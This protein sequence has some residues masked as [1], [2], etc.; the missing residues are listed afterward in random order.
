MSP[1]VTPPPPTPTPVL[2]ADLTVTK[3]GVPNPVAGEG[4]LTYFITVRNIGDIAAEAST[5][6]DTL[7]GEVGLISATPSQGTCVAVN[8]SLGTIAPG[9]SATIT[10]I[11]KVSAGVVGD[12]D[13]T[14]CVATSTPEVTLDNNCDMTTVTV[15]P[16][17][18]PTT[19]PTATPPG[20]TP[21]P[22]PPPGPRADL[23]IAKAASPNP[24]AAQGTV[25]YGITVTNLG[26]DI[27][28]NVMVNE[29]LPSHVTLVSET[30]SQ[31]SCAANLCSL[32]N[33]AAGQTVAIAVAVKVK[34]GVTGDIQNIAC[35][36]SEM[37]DPDLGNNCAT[38]TV[39]VPPAST[40]TPVALTVE[41]PP[42]KLPS[43]GGG[44]LGS[45]SWQYWLVPGILILLLS[46]AVLA[47]ASKRGS[48]VRVRV[49]VR[50]DD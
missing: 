19:S 14:V 10:A 27:A 1:T 22:T 8:C 29:A 34:P 37:P 39:T 48:R 6:L 30:P 44:M 38:A 7:P 33:M 40:P 45:D 12:I 32:G 50:K 36:A 28:S 4:T 25:T 21:T 18:T 35:V 47:A 23:V 20:S 43:T 49:R 13:N 16:T 2:L 31:G 9:G 3:I 5:A 41:S 15:E 17:P 11:V 24:V 46:G 42:A 26:P